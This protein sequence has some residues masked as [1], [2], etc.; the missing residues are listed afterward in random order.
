M[1]LIA[2]SANLDFV[3]QVPA[4]P[5]PGETVLGDELAVG[6][7]GKGANQAVACA[8]AGNAVTEML[9]ALGDDLFAE[10]IESSLRDA[11]VGLHVKRVHGQRTGAALITVDGEG[12]NAITVAS[13]ANS[14]L[15]ADE[16]PALDGCTH[17][18]MQLETPVPVIAECA[19]IASEQGVS[20]VLNA[21]PAQTL[22]SELSALLDVIIV[23]EGE[24]SHIA[25]G[26][27]SVAEQAA[28]IAVPCVVVTLGR[29]GCYAVNG[30][31]EILFPGY[32]VDSVD[33]TGAGDTFCGVLV[34]ALGDGQSLGSAIQRA[35]AAA[36][37]TCTGRGAQD[38]IPTRERV[39]RFLRE[40]EA[41][42]LPS[43]IAELRAYCGVDD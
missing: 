32:D 12:E 7:G 3:V 34:A 43:R 5:R 40:A 19:R 2:G 9:V 28:S 8:R 36:A 22:E 33:T 21:A 35:S 30:D 29:R 41:V 4:I 38:S 31:T 16:L 10:T 14:A 23:N 42:P 24:L 17:L 6:S 26:G 27:G 20:V 37:L 15:S 25:G 13:G 18:L 1:I 11:G 39:D